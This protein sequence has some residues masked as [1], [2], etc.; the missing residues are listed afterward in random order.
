MPNPHQFGLDSNSI[1]GGKACPGHRCYKIHLIK[2]ICQQLWM[3]S[4]L[5]LCLNH[6]MKISSHSRCLLWT[7]RLCRYCNCN[8]YKLCIFTYVSE[9][10]THFVDTFFFFLQEN[11]NIRSSSSRC[12]LFNFQ[13]SE[14]EKSV[15]EILH[16]MLN[17][18][19]HLRNNNPVTL[20][21]AALK[22]MRN[23]C[24]Q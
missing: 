21:K 22:H 6:I 17:P 23:A 11:K 8:T 14:E 5:E 12:I 16:Y 4:V 18:K 9:L 24:I 2:S 10:T 1:K 15:L 3:K 7:V 20:R 19:I 13:N